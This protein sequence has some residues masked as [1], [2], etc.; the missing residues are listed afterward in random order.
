MNSVGVG[1]GM[2]ELIVLLM[3]IV[4]WVIPLAIAVWVVVTLRRLRAG[5]QAV[6]VKLDAIERLLQRS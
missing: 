3:M 1:V 6:Q 5:Q 4:T 2:P